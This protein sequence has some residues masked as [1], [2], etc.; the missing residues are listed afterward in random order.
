MTVTVD[1]SDA[2]IYLFR[3]EPY[4][5]GRPGDPI[6]RLVPRP[7]SVRNRH[8]LKCYLRG[9]GD[10]K[11]KS[12]RARGIDN[13]RI[14]PSISSYQILAGL[15]TPAIDRTGLQEGRHPY[16]PQWAFCSWLKGGTAIIIAGPEFDCLEL[17]NDRT[18]TGIHTISEPVQDF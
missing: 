4:E 12:K 8:G 17:G 7:T 13:S 16:I 18:V 2:T 14:V 10:R 6:P 11:R 9:R 5:I 3:Y 15:C 1:P